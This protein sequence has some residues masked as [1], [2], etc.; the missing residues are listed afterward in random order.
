MK[1]LIRDWWLIENEEKMET[2]LVCNDV[3]FTREELVK[4]YPIDKLL[5]EDVRDLDGKALTKK[6][7]I[8]F[9]YDVE[10]DDS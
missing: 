10:E 3:E 7:I 4:K 8:N 5:K 6:Q 2:N 1:V 9:Y